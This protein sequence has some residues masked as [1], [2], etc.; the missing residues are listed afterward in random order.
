MQASTGA[1]VLREDSEFDAFKEKFNNGRL[2][3]LAGLANI[4]FLTPDEITEGMFSHEKN[5]ENYI[6]MNAMYGADETVDVPAV[7]DL[8]G[9]ILFCCPTVA[10]YGDKWYLVSVSS[11]T[12]MIMGIATNRQAF[13]AAEGSL[14]DLLK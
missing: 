13:A 2:E 6:I 9:E 11:M 10:R 8:D 5:Q 14:D 12:N 4:R 1:I 7:A 3:K